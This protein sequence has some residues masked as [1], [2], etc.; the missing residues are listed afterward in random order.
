MH[1]FDWI[2]LDRLELAKR[3]SFGFDTLTAYP[4]AGAVSPCDGYVKRDSA[5]AGENFAT[6]RAGA[7]TT[8]SVAGVNANATYLWV[9]NITS[10]NFN[11]LFRGFWLFDTSGLTASATISA[12]VLSLFGENKSNGLGDDSIE[13]VSAT[14]AA[15]DTLENADYSQV[16]TTSFSSI[17]YADFSATAYN[18]FTLS[19]GG[20]ANVSKTG[21][22][23]FATRGGWDLSGTFGGIWGNGLTSRFLVTVSSD[24][25]A[26]PDPKLVVT[27]TLPTSGAGVMVGITF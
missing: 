3:F 26:S 24:A 27:Y 5:A 18:D 22:S 9:D 25:G 15:T 16:G 10:G 19:A 6:I 11:S 12:T 13:I 23:K 2:V 1:F 20:R 8:F 4:A 21:I 7:G 14:P 17:A